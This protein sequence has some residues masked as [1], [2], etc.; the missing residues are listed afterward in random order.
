MKSPFTGGEAILKKELRTMNFRKE[1][2]EIWFRFYKCKD[3]GEQFTTDE[4]DTVNTNQVYNQ[5][6]AKYG[7]PFPDEIKAIREQYGLSA[8]KMSEILG[9]GT[10]RLPQL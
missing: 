7:I 5:Y 1:P 6:R 10:N 3:S 9:L 2:F 8:H 4:L